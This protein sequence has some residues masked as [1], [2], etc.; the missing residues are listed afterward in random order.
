MSSSANAE[1]RRDSAEV[2]DFEPTTQHVPSERL[3]A[4]PTLLTSIFDVFPIKYP[5]LA[6]LAIA[7]DAAG[8]FGLSRWQQG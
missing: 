6:L 1:E 5:V 3:A 2:W 8:N 4:V 7:L